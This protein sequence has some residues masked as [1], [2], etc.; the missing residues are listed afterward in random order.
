M[1]IN[2]PVAWAHPVMKETA[3]NNQQTCLKTV[4]FTVKKIETEIKVGQTK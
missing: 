3:G 1:S 2:D 4:F